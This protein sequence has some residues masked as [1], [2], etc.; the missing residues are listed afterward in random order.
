MLKTV[1]HQLSV[2]RAVD[3]LIVM[4]TDVVVMGNLL[5]LWQTFAQFEPG[6]VLGMAHVHAVNPTYIRCGSVGLN[7]G[8][9]LQHLAAMRRHALYV[10]ANKSGRMKRSRVW[11]IFL[12]SAG[13]SYVQTSKRDR[14]ERHP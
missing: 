5:R 12:I 13:A 2:L 10:D 14:I 11:V 6:Q 4:D 3:K 7:G 9:Q 1:L 8:L